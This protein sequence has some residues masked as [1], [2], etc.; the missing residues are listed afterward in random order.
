[1]RLEVAFFI[2][3]IAKNCD[4]NQLEVATIHDAFILRKSDLDRFMLI[5]SSVFELLNVPGPALD[6]QLLQPET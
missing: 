3:V 4:D 5:F 1:M 2:K 6:I